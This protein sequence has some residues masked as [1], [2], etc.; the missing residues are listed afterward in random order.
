MALPGDVER[1]WR[2]RSEMTL[3]RRGR[4]MVHRRCGQPACAR[5]VRDARGDGHSC[6]ELDADFRPRPSA[7]RATALMHMSIAR[8]RSFSALCTLGLMAAHGHVVAGTG[9]FRA[10]EP[11]G[12]SHIVAV[13]FVTLAL[14]VEDRRAILASVQPAR[15][16][17]AALVAR[18]A[19]PR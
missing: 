1:W 16:A 13:P 14:I 7:Q 9:R 4:I 19:G 5:C 17:G 11:N 10:G 2:S 15:L 3:V 12:A 6:T 18:R 8:E